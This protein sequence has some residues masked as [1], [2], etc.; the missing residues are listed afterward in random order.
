MN[1]HKLNPRER[2]VGWV[3]HPH[4]R[5]GAAVLA[6]LGV[7]WALVTHRYPWWLWAPACFLTGFLMEALWYVMAYLYQKSTYP[8]RA[9]EAK[10]RR[11]KERGE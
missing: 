10:R 8:Q 3:L 5:D 4:T 1:G 7:G 6:V 11:K 9:R 2:V